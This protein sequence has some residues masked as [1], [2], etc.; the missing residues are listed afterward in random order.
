MEG[1][2]L[3]K[4]IVK[5]ERIH[6]NVRNI[7]LK[8]RDR[9]PYQICI[10]KKK[11]EKKLHG[12]RVH[13]CSNIFYIKLHCITLSILFVLVFVYQYGCVGMYCCI[14][15]YLLFLPPN[16]ILLFFRYFIVYIVYIIYFILYTRTAQMI[17]F[18][19]VFEMEPWHTR[20]Q[21]HTRFSKKRPICI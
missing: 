14:V 19:V 10:K 4:G 21:T 7:Y 17:S 11:T 8:L 13:S 20:K 5:C 16:N 18:L 6:T 12:Q 3:L 1:G 2:E 15:W 9:M